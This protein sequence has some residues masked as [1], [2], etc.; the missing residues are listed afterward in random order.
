MKN[1]THSLIAYSLAVALLSPTFS[2]F[3]ATETLH[4]QSKYTELMTQ[5]QVVDQLLQQAVDAFK[6]PARISHA[7]F[8]AKLPSNMET[9]A[10]RLLTAYT[11]EPYRA[12]LL[13]SA[14]NAYIYNKDINKAIQIFEKV[15]TLAPDDLDAHT[16][17]AT[18]QRFNDNQA[19]VDKHLNS[20]KVLSPARYQQLQ[21]LFAVV[22]TVSKMPIRDTLPG[23]LGADSAIVVLGYA[24]NP[25]GSMHDIL[26][27][28]LEKALE[29]TNQ[30]PQALV[31]VTGGVPHNNQTE[32][33]L[34]QKWLVQKGVDAKRIVQ[35][36]YATST[37]ENA[38]YSRYA[39][40]Q[41]RIKQAVVLSSGSHVRRGQALL[42]I[43]TWET[44]PHDI[45]F[46]S[47]AAPDKAL[48]ELQQVSK[49][50]LLGI[51]RDSLRVMGMWSFR[52]SPLLER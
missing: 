28:R 34:M 18:W 20:L 35:D 14:A 12:D 3:S 42:Q 10:E 37:V 6:S 36:N 32:A 52:S 9:V 38:L 16:Y 8:T 19:E 13:F 45:T 17:L 11:L 50:D 5:R 44:G 48:E 25:D 47:I 21:K 30:S 7:G 1:K 39:L 22:D 31:I 24:L 23:P 15:L 27:K 29:L 41:H 43:A 2:V 51:Y 33:D 46:E 40:T 26:I 49:D 4:P